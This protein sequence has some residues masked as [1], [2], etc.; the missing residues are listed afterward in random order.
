MICSIFIAKHCLY[1]QIPAKF[2][3]LHSGLVNVHYNYFMWAALL[4]FPHFFLFLSLRFDISNPTPRFVLRA[5][6]LQNGAVSI[7][8]CL[9]ALILNL[10]A[11]RYD[12]RMYLFKEYSDLYSDNSVSIW[13]FYILTVAV[14][15]V[16]L[17]LLYFCF[18][19]IFLCNFTFC[20]SVLLLYYTFIIA[21]IFFL[22]FYCYC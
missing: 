7:I 10:V 16:Y 17:F 8:F 2:Y 19:T 4:I 20:Y 6:T 3:V 21:F 12:D 14:I 15:H 9:T 13:Y 1:S 5:L 11:V 22:Y 18:H